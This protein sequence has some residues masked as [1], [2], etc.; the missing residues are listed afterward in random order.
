MVMTAEEIPPKKFLT[1]KM[2]PIAFFL[3][4][5][6]QKGSTVADLRESGGS[7]KQKKI[8]KENKNQKWKRL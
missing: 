4:G 1:D 8:I 7:E 6:F 3:R 2:L 5:H